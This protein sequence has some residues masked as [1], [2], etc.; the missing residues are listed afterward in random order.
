[1]T[2]NDNPQKVINANENIRS[3]W[4]RMGDID[5]NNRQAKHIPFADWLIKN[6]CPSWWR[7]HPETWDYQL[8]QY[9]LCLTLDY[10][11]STR[12]TTLRFLA[13]ALECNPLILIN[14]V[15]EELKSIPTLTFPTP[16]QTCQTATDT[17]E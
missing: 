10:P 17:N 7:N 4:L 3:S 2:E 5:E 12:E 15:R 1:M 16:S 9:L 13:I 6:F 8:N 14:D 11:R